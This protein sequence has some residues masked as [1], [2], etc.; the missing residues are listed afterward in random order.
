MT[1]NNDVEAALGRF[2]TGCALFL[3]F[4]VLL[5]FMAYLHG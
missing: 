5:N 4:I 2:F 3:L 1:G